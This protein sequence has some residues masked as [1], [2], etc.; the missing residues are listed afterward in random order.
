MSCRIES[1]TRVEEV[2]DERVELCGCSGADSNQEEAAS[3]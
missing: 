1:E 2:R 3:F